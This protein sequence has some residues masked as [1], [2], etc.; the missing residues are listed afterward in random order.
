MLIRG[1]AEGHPTNEI[2]ARTLWRG[3]TPS[4][5]AAE[6]NRDQQKSTIEP[7]GEL[8]QALIL[9]LNFGIL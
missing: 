3:E 6:L 8:L 9:S 5:R 7:G 4:S 1:S 2:L